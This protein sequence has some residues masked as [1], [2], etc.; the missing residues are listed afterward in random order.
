MLQSAGARVVIAMVAIG[1]IYALLPYTGQESD[2]GIPEATTVFVSKHE[3]RSVSSG[4]G[5]A[6]LQDE[7]ERLKEELRIA[8]QGSNSRVFVQQHDASGDL[9]ST[10]QSARYWRCCV[11]PEYWSKGCQPCMN[12]T[13]RLWVDE[14]GSWH[15]IAREESMR[16]AREDCKSISSKPRSLDSCW[17]VKS[18]GIALQDQR[19]LVIAG[20]QKNG[21]KVFTKGVGLGNQ[22][23]AAAGLIGNGLRLGRIPA[24]GCNSC[25]LHSMLRN[26]HCVEKLDFTQEQLDKTLLI[27]DGGYLM[28][29]EDQMKIRNASRDTVIDYSLFFQATSTFKDYAPAV[30]SAMQPSKQI[31]ERVEEYFESIIKGID[32]TKE[33]RTVAI[34]VRRGDYTAARHVSR[35]GLLSISYF[36][37]GLK[38]IRDQLAL[39]EPDSASKLVAIVFTTQESVEW[40]EKDFSKKL[41]KVVA[42]INVVCANTSGFTFAEGKAPPAESRCQGEEIDMLAMALADYI[43]LSNSTF[44]WWS[45]FFS[46]CRTKIIDWWNIIS[47][48]FGSRNRAVNRPAFV[49]PTVWMNEEATKINSGAGEFSASKFGGGRTQTFQFMSSDYL[50]TSVSLKNLYQKA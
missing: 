29:I 39:E 34:H 9:P 38:L 5:A 36:T 28:K 44:S 3:P 40:C 41:G 20:G 6:D 45:H 37:E 43:I 33:T 50:L 16:K 13:A 19:G 27:S 12:M 8:K 31:Q 22:L 49:L 18:N 24:V 14:S 1:C 47:S 46:I 7:I 32:I 17:H 21:A 2:D 48:T 23:F 26:M 42:N 35:Y 4:L 25:F 11:S 10:W 30:C 15:G